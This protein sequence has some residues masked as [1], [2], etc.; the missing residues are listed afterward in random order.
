MATQDKIR[1]SQDYAAYLLKKKNAVI[2]VKPIKDCIS[3]AKTVDPIESW[4]GPTFE[5]RFAEGAAGAIDLT[6]DKD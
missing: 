2:I 5:E 1:Y 4:D 6:M 3:E